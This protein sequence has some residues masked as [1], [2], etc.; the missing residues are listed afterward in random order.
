MP[1]SLENDDEEAEFSPEDFKID[2]DD[3]FFKRP[4]D[5]DLEVEYADED[6]EE[7]VAYGEIVAS[8]YEQ[9]EDED[10]A[11]ADQE[12]QGGSCPRKKD[13]K[14]P[15]SETFCCLTYRHRNLQ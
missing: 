1:P 9:P 14:K 15:T 5:D 4:P 12:C 11:D 13:E 3:D 7:E 8:N 2:F 10:K 6:D